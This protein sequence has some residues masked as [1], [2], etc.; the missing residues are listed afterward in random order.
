MRILSLT[1]LLVAFIS[2]KAF[3]QQNIPYVLWWF[4]ENGI[5]PFSGWQSMNIL[6]DTLYVCGR[7]TLSLKGFVA[8][9]WTVFP[10]YNVDYLWNNGGTSSVIAVDQSGNYACSMTISANNGTLITTVVDSIQ[11]VFTD[12]DADIESI[13]QVPLCIPPLDLNILSVFGATGNVDFHWITVDGN[14][15]GLGQQSQVLSVTELVDTVVVKVRIS[16]N[17]CTLYTDAATILPPSNTDPIYKDLCLVTLDSA[18]Q[19]HKLV[20]D[21]MEQTGIVAYRLYRQDNVSS[22]YV[23]MHE[24]PID[25]L[26]E[27]VDMLSNPQQT[28][29]RYQ[30]AA[31]D[32]CGTESQHYNTHTTVLLSSN[33]GINNTVNLSWNAYEGFEYPNF[34][35]WRSADGISFTLLSNV[36]N[37][38]F[39]FVDNNPLPQGFYQVRVSN[40]NGC[41]SSRSS[42]YNG[43]V[44]NVVDN[45]GNPAGIAAQ[46][47]I[48][49]S[50]YPNPSTGVFEVR[51]ATSV[52]SLQY[53]VV[54]AAGRTIL[55]GTA[56]ATNRLTLELGNYSSGIYALHLQTPR[57]ISI[58]KL[59]L[60]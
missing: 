18:T 25:S 9:D 59:M 43:S 21:N 45:Q 58:K 29:S 5:T 1:V 11:V 49:A 8:S 56:T 40:P 36:P 7:D 31:V 15:L 13:V 57:G 12:L 35:I 6:Q 30:I 46:Q 50:I 20:W 4:P 47:Q 44:S 2:G 10:D 55:Q 42:D 19:K 26:S 60:H 24:Q 54:D 16:D 23:L 17:N 33:Q 52:T 51:L 38:T 53:S 32:S 27:Y 37:N 14:G 41:V 48:E 3:S 28:V 39:S 34:E 22:N